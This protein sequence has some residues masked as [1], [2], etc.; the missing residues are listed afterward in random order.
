MTASTPQLYSHVPAR[1]PDAPVFSSLKKSAASAQNAQVNPPPA[2]P[3]L[4]DQVSARRPALVQR[5]PYQT[6]S[7]HNRTETRPYT[8]FA[9]RYRTVLT[10]WLFQGA[11][12]KLR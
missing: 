11:R 10:A 12:P 5:L 7:W 1:T 4:L 8:V 3:A 6:Y 2:F 9:A